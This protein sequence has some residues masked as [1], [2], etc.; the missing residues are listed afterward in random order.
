MKMRPNLIIHSVSILFD[1]VYLIRVIKKSFT[2]DY[3]GLVS[4][5]SDRGA[6]AGVVYRLD[7]GTFFMNKIGGERYVQKTKHTSPYLRKRG[8]LKLKHL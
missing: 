2:M 8:Y 7:D 5:L 4:Q 6:F 1:K 3:F